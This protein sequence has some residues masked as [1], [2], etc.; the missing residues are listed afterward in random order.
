MAKLING[1]NVHL[2]ALKVPRPMLVALEQASKL[3]GVSRPELVRLVLREE[4]E[5]ILKNFEGRNG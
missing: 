4:L 1:P 5:A 3:V 2:L